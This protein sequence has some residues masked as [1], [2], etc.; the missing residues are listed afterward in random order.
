MTTDLVE[1]VRLSDGAVLWTASR[2]RPGAPAV[3]LLHGGPGMWDY[4]AP[5]ADLLGEVGT[6]RYDQ[7]GCG[8]SSAVREYR[9]AQYVSDLDE[10]RRHH[11]QER[12]TV[13]G[14]SSGAGLALAYAAA[15]PDRVESLIYCAGVGL[16]WPA[17]RAEFRTRSRSRLSAEQAA[18]LDELEAMGAPARTREQEVHWRALT[19]LPDA[20]PGEA[21]ERWAYEAAS[22]RLP[23]TTACN[24]AL[25]PQLSARG[26]DVELAEAGSIGAPVLVLHGSTDPRPVEAVEAL[27]EALPDGRLVVVDGAGHQP[28]R[29]RP[30]AFAAAMTEF[31]A[32]RGARRP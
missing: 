13:F 28:W 19:W 32:G 10:L 5:V 21:A 1:H 30:S 27:V 15:H 25:W 23:L 6:Y 29:E 4:L 18:H 16:D 3:V 9:L 17:Q 20:A 31:L 11:G 8:R 12:W 26:L 14:H 22:T 24:R 2:P 7:R